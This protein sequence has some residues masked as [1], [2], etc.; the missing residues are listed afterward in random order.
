MRPPSY[1]HLHQPASA[2][3]D[4]LHVLPAAY[5]QEHSGSPG[6]QLQFDF[7]LGFAPL[8]PVRALSVSSR[9]TRSSV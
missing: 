1:G 8:P 9:F 5:K 3:P 4:F 6:V 2:I 7:G